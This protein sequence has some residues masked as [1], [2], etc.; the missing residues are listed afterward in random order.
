MDIQ[1]DDIKETKDLGEKLQILINKQKSFK[2]FVEWEDWL[3]IFN[4]INDQY[5]ES[6]NKLLG[7]HG[8]KYIN[9]KNV[10]DLMI[11]NDCEMLV[12]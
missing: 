6:Y 1:L 3:K 7:T 4:P 5:N 10:V 8:L 11:L 12:D 2:F 9:F